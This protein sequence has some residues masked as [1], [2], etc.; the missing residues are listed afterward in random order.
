LT[1]P[2]YTLLLLLP[3]MEP[4]SE[5]TSNGSGEDDRSEELPALERGRGNGFCGLDGED[6]F[7][8]LFFG[9]MA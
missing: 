8:R 6:L 5:I 9:G 3:E 4:L 7:T 1:E 2:I